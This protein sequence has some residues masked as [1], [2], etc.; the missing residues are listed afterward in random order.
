MLLQT[1]KL[2]KYVDKCGPTIGQS[3]FNYYIVLSTLQVKKEGG[4]LACDCKEKY[5]T[6]IY[7]QYGN[8]HTDNLDLI[9]NVPLQNIMEM[10]G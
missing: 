3:I 4:R 1:I 2:N 10:G 5:N 7:K 8:V 9:V 6:F